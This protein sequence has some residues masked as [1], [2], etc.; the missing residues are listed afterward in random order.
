M[1]ASSPEQ[2]TAALALPAA[3]SADVTIQAVDGPANT[4]VVARAVTI[5][6]GETVTLV[7]RRH[8]RRHTT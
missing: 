2:L 1:R 6:V 7:L 4:W 8:Q 3:A 5:K